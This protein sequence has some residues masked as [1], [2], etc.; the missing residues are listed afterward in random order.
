MPK[1]IITVGEAM[2]E[3]RRNDAAGWDQGFAGDTL[4]VAWALRAL[5]SADEAYVGFLTRIGTDAF[6]NHFHEFVSASG[7]DADFLAPDPDRTIGLYTIETDSTGER[8]FSYWRGQSAARQLASKPDTLL[9][10]L[11]GADLVYFSGIT[12]AILSTKDRDGFFDVLG[13][14]KQQGA[15]LAFDPNIRPRL[16]EDARTMCDAVEAA[17]SLSDIVLPTFDDESSA[18]G[19]ANPNDTLARY[20]ALGVREV[21]VKDGV[22]ATRYISDEEAGEIEV[23]NVVAAL[24]TTGAGDSFNG[25]FLASRLRGL[26]V[27][28]AIRLGQAVSKA[29]VGQRGALI[30]MSAMREAIASYIQQ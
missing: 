18:F 28:A 13:A 1:T 9:R 21:V 29:V 5:L 3:F 24:D 20:R 25:A 15:Q 16:W 7:I 22:N 19:D 4:N 11:T 14:M 2:V 6:S 8:E 12:L 30:D 26:N 27:P 10:A 23:S 17:A